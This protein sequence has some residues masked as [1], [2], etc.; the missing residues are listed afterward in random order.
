[1][2]VNHCLNQLAAR[3]FDTLSLIVSR[4]NSRELR[5]DQALGLQEALAFP[6]FVWES[7]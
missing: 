3:H 1:M 6:V 2:L 5:L 7:S 4:A